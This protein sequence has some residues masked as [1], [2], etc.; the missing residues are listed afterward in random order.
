M[1]DQYFGD[2]ND[3]LKYG[4]L[5]CLAEA[6]WQLGVVWMLTP[7]DE[8]KDG[9]KTKYLDAPTQWRHYD[10]PLFD[11]LGQ[12]VRVQ[13][14]RLVAHAEEDG[15]L[16][17]ARFYGEPVPKEQGARFRWFK[18]GLGKLSGA[19]LLFFDPDNGLEVPSVR[20][21]RKGAD[22][23]LTWHEVDDAWPRASL[24]IF[25]HIPHEDHEKYARRKAGELGEHTPGGLVIPLETENVLFLL[26][27]HP[28]HAVLA[29]TATSRIRAQ[30]SGQIS[31]LE[32][33]VGGTGVAPRPREQLPLFDGDGGA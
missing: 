11:K 16:P 12:V 6:G 10:P 24:L 21:S 23:Y 9:N 29:E 17:A 31:I 7:P 2:I 27:C 25:Q 8:R 19:S 14:S 30:W 1:K 3:Y 20:P 4:I 32:H 28:E 22:K 26:A 33:V 15:L 13:E 5:R 18:D